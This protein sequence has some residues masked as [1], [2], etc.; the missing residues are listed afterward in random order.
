MGLKR[1][2]RPRAT[3][4]ASRTTMAARPSSTCPSPAAGT[5]TFVSA[6]ISEND[7]D[8]AR[9]QAT[10]ARRAGL[11]TLRRDSWWP[12]PYDR[13][14]CYRDEPDPATRAWRLPQV[15]AGR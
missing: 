12:P 14:G 4:T 15:E 7:V 1:C 10:P 9:I 3:T 2:H 13:S 11:R 6:P 5:A 8:A